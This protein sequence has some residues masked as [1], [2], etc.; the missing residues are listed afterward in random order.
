MAC[1]DINQSYNA[2]VSCHLELVKEVEK[3][4][5]FLA[6]ALFQGEII[7]S[8][9]LTM[10]QELGDSGLT[11]KMKSERLVWL[12]EERVKH[13]PW[14]YDDI[15]KIFRQKPDVF[16]QLLVTLERRK[17]DIDDID[18]VLVFESECMYNAY[19]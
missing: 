12:M 10:V 18:N 2:M 15:I 1:P 7:C 11:P 16:G 5:R 4:Y 9:Q 8:Q 14:R 13:C 3:D 17:N 6:N 19:K